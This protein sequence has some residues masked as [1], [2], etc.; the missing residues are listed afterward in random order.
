MRGRTARGGWSAARYALWI[1]G[2]LIT[3]LLC[4]CLG[5]VPV[6][7]GDTL[8]ALGSLLTGV[9]GGGAFET[10]LLSV[11]LPRVLTAAFTGASL[12]LCG[13]AMQGL[14]KNPL[15]DGST[16]GVSSGAALGA[17]SAIALGL[18][19]PGLP[20]GGTAV[21]AMLG[22]LI[23]LLAILFLAYRIDGSLSTNTVILVGVIFSMFASSIVSLIVTLAPEKTRAITFW[24]MGSF[25]GASYTSAATLLGALVVCGGALL[26]LA[27]ALNAF[28]AGESNALSVGVNVRMVKPVTLVCVAALT[29]ACVAVGGTIGFVGLVVPHMARMLFGPDHR[30]LLPGSMFSGAIFLMLCD[31]AA[32]AA[33]APRELPVGVITSFIV[34]AAFQYIFYTSRKRACG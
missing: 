1:G 26:L 16:L 4:L 15:A 25:S 13:A 27:D 8:R 23:A 22:A 17:V 11:R 28:A 12:S 14:L 29:G 5:S 9:R 21:A 18:S 19:L 32:R 33:F 24:T 7:L 2:T 10:I 20:L 30:R 34:A 6:P 31:L 3:A